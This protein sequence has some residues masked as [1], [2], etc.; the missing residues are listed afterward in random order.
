M[1]LPSAGRARRARGPMAWACAGQPF[2]NLELHHMN[3]L[4][5]ADLGGHPLTR[6]QPELRAPLGERA[7]RLTAFVESL[8]SRRFAFVTLAEAAARFGRSA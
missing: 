8:K 5:A 1:A 6:L 3:S 7:D 2:V 4:D